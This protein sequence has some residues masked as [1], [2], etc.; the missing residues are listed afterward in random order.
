MIEVFKTNINDAAIAAQ[1]VLELYKHM[2]ASNINFDLDDCDRIL[3]I[4][5]ESIILEKVH[6]VFDSKGF[7]CEQ[8]LD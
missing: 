8:L 6:F 1:I 5:S 4:E 2:P 7:E 3:R